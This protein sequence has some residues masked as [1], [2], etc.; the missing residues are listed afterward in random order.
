MKFQLSQSSG[1]LLAA[2]MSSLG[3]VACVSM[4]PNTIVK[5]STIRFGPNQTSSWEQLAVLALQTEQVH[6]PDVTF[7]AL[8]LLLRFVTLP[9]HA[10]LLDS[11]AWN[12]QLDFGATIL[13]A[14]KTSKFCW[15]YTD[16]LSLFTSQLNFVNCRTARAICDAE[17]HILLTLGFDT[18]ISTTWATTSFLLD[19]L[20]LDKCQ[21]L[22]RLCFHI[23]L[24]LY[25][26]DQRFEHQSGDWNE[27]SQRC[28]GVPLSRDSGE[29]F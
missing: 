4:F 21:N 7:A 12:M 3:F 19:S 17:M 23:T 9:S 5:L 25:C 1:L 15:S 11:S 29:L 16:N 10:H 14:A 27:N 18:N 24:L 28:A 26:I 6:G 2:T 20:G 22:V 13:I 8:E